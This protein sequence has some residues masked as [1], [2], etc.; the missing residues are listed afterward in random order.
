MNQ[1]VRAYCHHVKVC[2][3][4][5]ESGWGLEQEQEEES[6]GSCDHVTHHMFSVCAEG[7]L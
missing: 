4:K 3:E 2:D 6:R 1:K 7:R 5:G